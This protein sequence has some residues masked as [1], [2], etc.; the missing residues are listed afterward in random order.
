MTLWH[1]RWRSY[2]DLAPDL[3]DG[4]PLKQAAQRSPA[5]RRKHY[6]VHE[7][8]VAADKVSYTNYFE[9]VSWGG[10]DDQAHYPVVLG[11]ITGDE[12]DLRGCVEGNVTARN[13]CCERIVSTPVGCSHALTVREVCMVHSTTL[14]AGERATVHTAVLARV[15]ALRAPLLTVGHSFRFPTLARDYDWSAHTL[16]E[17]QQHFNDQE[18]CSQYYGLDV[19]AMLPID[20]GVRDAQPHHW[21]R[22]AP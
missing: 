10:H 4:S 14:A 5:L 11:N 22:Q 7:G 2:A 19:R 15:G 16:A 1:P 8:D 17:L 21:L 13:L 20:H 18:L 9:G 12:L 3:S 6:F